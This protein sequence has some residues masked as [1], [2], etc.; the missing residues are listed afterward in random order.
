ML[1]GAGKDKKK[2]PEEQRRLSFDVEIQWDVAYLH[3]TNFCLDPL[4]SSPSTSSET[5]VSS[6]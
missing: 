5:W 1:Q 6:K 3:C 2:V 4:L